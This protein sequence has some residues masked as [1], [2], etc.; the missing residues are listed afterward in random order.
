MTTISLVIP[1]INGRE[2]S[3]ERT[4]R[5]YAENRDRNGPGVLVTTRM[6]F[7][8]IGAAWVDV[9]PTLTTDLAHL[10]T[11][12][13]TAECR[14][15]EAVVT[16]WEEN[17]GLAVPLMLKMPEGTLESHG[18]HGVMHTE[19]TEVGWVGVPI[20]PSCCYDEGAL[21]LAACGS[22]HYY[23]DNILCDVMRSHGHQLIALPSYRLG[24][25]WEGGGADGSTFGREGEAWRVWRILHE[26]PSPD[27][28]HAAWLA[29]AQAKGIE[30]HG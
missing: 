15:Q 22:P 27:A 23:S 20:I 10:G 21:A 8:S 7:P 28:P 24:H 5:S 14:W 17:G 18:A 16:E 11:D 25:W 12:D 1:T 19:R 13:V 26:M 29:Y 30:R 4:V 2:A 3:F 9:L 6:N